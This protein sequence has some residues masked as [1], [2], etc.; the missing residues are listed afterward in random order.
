MKNYYT[1]GEVAK[2]Y[3][4]G[5][6]S[7]M[8]YEDLGLLKPTRNE[9][10]YRFYGISDIWR[11]NLIKELRSLD[12]PMKRIKAYVETRD[13]QSTK[14]MLQEERQMI[15][16][17]IRELT[18]YQKNI[19]YRLRNI[20]E[21]LHES[22]ECIQE[23]TLGERKGMSLA[24]HITR[25]EEV[26]IL[27]QKLQQAY[28]QQISIIG[29]QHIGAVFDREAFD[30]G[31]YNVFQAVFCLVEE[32]AYDFVLPGGKYITY[33][34]KGPYKDN[35]YAIEKLLQHIEEKKYIVVGNPIEIYKV[36]V[37][38]TSCEDDYRTEIQ[39]PIKENVLSQ[40]G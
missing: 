38:E 30:Q 9:K 37:H 17:K 11:L 34:Y 40:E 7:L 22:E 18:S 39:I 6:D 13:L 12:M 32:E 14:Q 16:A 1:I 2:I 3:G 29:N 26:D 20:E 28:E 19:D 23:K 24:A 27:M 10:G 4:I 21:V 5:K 33:T 15:E 35:K 25:D 8:Y 36:D 31:T